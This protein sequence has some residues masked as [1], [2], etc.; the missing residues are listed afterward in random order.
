M[1]DSPPRILYCHC[2]YAQAIPKEVKEAVAQPAAA[3]AVERMTAHLT[4][5]GV[6]L[7][8]HPIRLGASLPMTGESFTGP[9]AE[10]ANALL[11]GSY[12]KGFEITV[13]HAAPFQVH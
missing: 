5:N 6:D 1:S 11:K 2:Q 7:D 12:R 4:A 9:A 3:D 10:K 13:W 8:K